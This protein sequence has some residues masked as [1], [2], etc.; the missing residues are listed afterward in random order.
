MSE[1]YER[2]FSVVFKQRVGVGCLAAGDVCF[3]C[4]SKYVQCR[5]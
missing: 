1:E 4:H 2:F 5:Y 3:G